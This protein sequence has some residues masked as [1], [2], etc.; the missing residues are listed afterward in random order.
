M[1][2]LEKAKEAILQHFQQEQENREETT[3]REW[4]D[5]P[6]KEKTYT[7]VEVD[8]LIREARIAELETMK[9]DWG[10]GEYPR[11]D[12]RY[13]E[14]WEGYIDRRVQELSKH[15]EEGESV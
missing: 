8:R 10:Y 14:D 6:P 4:Y 13:G 3:K 12:Y 9:A 15:K 5:L 2:Y 7:Q 11:D 1:K